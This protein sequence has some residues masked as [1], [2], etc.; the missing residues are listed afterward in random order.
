MFYGV[1]S[2]YNTWLTFLLLFVFFLSYKAFDT[3]AVPTFES[4]GVVGA[5]G[6]EATCTAQGFFI[7]LGFAVPLYNCVLCMYFLLVIKYHKPERDLQKF[8]EPIGHLLSLGYPL[9][10]A[11]AG[12]VMD[13]YHSNGFFCWIEPYPYKCNE[14]PE[15]LFQ[16]KDWYRC[17]KAENAFYF[18]WIFGGI[19]LLF[20]FVAIAV[21][22]TVI[23]CSVR[24]R[25]RVM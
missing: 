16:T 18:Q 12:A 1:F 7:Q 2:T 11:I 25:V 6:S 23:Y 3:A 20:S 4:P 24:G 21:I 10:T 19:I 8:F 15:F 22:M 17:T 13:L 14:L 5:L 9:G